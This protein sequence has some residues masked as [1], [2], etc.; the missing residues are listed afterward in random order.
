M[1]DVLDPASM[2]VM[3]PTNERLARGF[4][5]LPLCLVEG[6][7][8]HESYRSLVV[9]LPPESSRWASRRLRYGESRL[10]GALDL[11]HRRWCQ[12]ADDT[13]DVCNG[14]SDQVLALNGRTVQQS[15]LLPVGRIDVDQELSRLL[16][17]PVCRLCDDGDDR[18]IQAKVV[19]IR[20]DH[21]SRAQL[22][23]GS[24]RERNG[25]Q[26]DVAAPDSHG[27]L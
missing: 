8:I 26:D 21:D 6:T 25:Q 24:R 3:S 5:L 15:R 18:I 7:R 2:R 17:R 10:E 14:D 27:F 16:G 1:A 23:P 4:D 12:T 11:R 20:F 9:K 19:V 22:G 13:T